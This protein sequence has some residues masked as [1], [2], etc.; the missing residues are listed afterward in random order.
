MADCDNLQRAEK[1]DMVDKLAKVQRA[2]KEAVEKFDEQT[3]VGHHRISHV[4]LLTRNGVLDA[5]QGSR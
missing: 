4:A 3:K 2:R 1:D 5:S